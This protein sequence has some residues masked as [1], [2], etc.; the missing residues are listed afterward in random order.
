V[1]RSI[2]QLYGNKLGASDGDIGQVKDFYFDDH[3]WAIRYVVV[4][5]GPWL[6]GRRVLVSP[7]SLGRLDQAEKILRVNLTRKQI[8]NSPSIDLQ[9]PVSRRDEEA[10]YRYFGWPYY[11]EGGKLWGLTGVPL[12]EA[13]PQ[14]P[15]IEPTVAFGPQIERAAAQ[16]RSVEAVTGYQVR[17]N[18]GTM[19]YVCDFMMDA[20]SWAIGQLVIK[21][22]HRFS[23]KEELIETK[24]VSSISYAESTVFATLT[25][26][27]IP[28]G[29]T[30]DLAPVIAAG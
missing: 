3:N 6:P 4:D 28:P 29:S 11:W 9:K 24:N 19:G 2:K 16:L 7:Y 18:N 26:E 15:R 27:S 23:G 25:A 14:S 13:A 8:E 20:D 17:T 30:A 21:T 12:L 10:Y 22:G 1:L 5:P